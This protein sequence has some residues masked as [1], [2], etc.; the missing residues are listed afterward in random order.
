M[1][2]SDCYPLIKKLNLRERLIAELISL[3]VAQNRLLDQITA[4][5]STCNIWCD[6]GIDH[7]ALLRE[8][9]VT[10]QVL[11]HYLIL[12][13]TFVPAHGQTGQHCPARLALIRS[14]ENFEAACRRDLPLPCLNC[15][16]ARSQL[17]EYYGIASPDRIALFCRS[18]I[19]SYLRE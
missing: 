2:T 8:A 3:H 7:L 18:I 17:S 13:A 4:D 6:H 19:A 11:N 5:I 12:V 16:K 15:A 10:R 14:H 1:E 9:N